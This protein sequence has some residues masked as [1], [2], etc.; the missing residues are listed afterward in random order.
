MF[1]NRIMLTAAL[2]F[3]TAAFGLPG[4]AAAEENVRI[5]GT[6]AGSIL[7]QH[8]VNSYQKT[9]PKANI[10]VIMPPLGSNGSLRALAD[11][12]IQIA[13]VS[14]L[15]ETLVSDSMS[16]IEWV[17]TPFVF[18]GKNLPA[19]THMTHDRLVDIYAGRYTQWPNA[20]PVRLVTRTERESDT[21]VL[22]AI[23]PAMDTAVT[24]AQQRPGMPFAEN[25]VENQKLLENT[26]GSFGAIALGQIR[27]SNSRLHP[28]VIDPTAPANSRSRKDTYR[29]VKTFGLIVSQTPSPETRDFLRYLRSP[30]AL[31]LIEPFGFTRAGA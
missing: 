6:G 24:A 29:F 5:G 3:A 14:V 1:L 19:G 30:E 11:G 9:H 16:V 23:S 4:T 27:L 7:L 13:V 10:A 22:R 2:S 28:V 12:S 15:P 31:R 20:T 26:E 21:K 18:V 17:K 8:L 25:D